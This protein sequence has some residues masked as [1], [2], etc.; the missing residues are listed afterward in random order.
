MGNLFGKSNKTNTEPD[1]NEYK[2]L[3]NKD[4]EDFT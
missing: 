3:S 2:S 1:N 4:N